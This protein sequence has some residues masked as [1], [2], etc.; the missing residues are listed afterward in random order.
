MRPG[1]R[2]CGA[3][4]SGTRTSC[5][6][7]ASRSSPCKYTINFGLEEVDGYQLVARDFYLPYLQAAGAREPAATRQAAGTGRRNLG[8]GSD[9]R[10]RAR[11]A[12][13]CTC[14]AS[15][16]RARPA[17]PSAS[18]RSTWT[19]RRSRPAV[20]FIDRPG[21]AKL[22]VRLPPSRTRCSTASACASSTT[23]DRGP[24]TS[25]T[26][27][28]TGSCSSSGSGTWSATTAPRD[29]RVSPRRA[30]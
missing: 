6:A 23:V 5:A 9:G 1:S 12:A 27:P 22:P 26:S 18:W 29:D 24:R 8:S 11:S 28:S 19:R 10:A 14:P 3:A 20:L 7:R 4:S 2:A 15:R 17:P 21:A 30:H 13:W 16:S 25:A